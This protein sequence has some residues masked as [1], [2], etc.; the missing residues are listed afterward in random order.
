MI[1]YKQPWNVASTSVLN[2]LFHLG[3]CVFSPGVL[4]GH[5]RR[6][7]ELADII[8]VLVDVVVKSSAFSLLWRMVAAHL[9]IASLVSAKV[10]PNRISLYHC[11]DICRWDG[12]RW[13]GKGWDK[14]GRD[15]IGW[16]GKPRAGVPLSSQWWFCTLPTALKSGRKWAKVKERRWEWQ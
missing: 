3:R 8:E 4:E 1:T 6:V 12:I 7:S 15:G 9:S 13:D 11:H 10:T 14:M 16:D 5:S 2:L